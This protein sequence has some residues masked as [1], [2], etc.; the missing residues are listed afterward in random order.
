MLPWWELGIKQGCASASPTSCSTSKPAWAGASLPSRS[1]RQPCEGYILPYRTSPVAQANQCRGAR[2]PLAAFLVA[3]ESP[4]G[5][6]GGCRKVPPKSNMCS[7]LVLLVGFLLEQAPKRA[8]QHL[9]CL[10]SCGFPCTL[11]PQLC[12]ITLPTDFETWAQQLAD[13]NH[14]PFVYPRAACAMPELAL[15]FD[16][17]SHGKSFIKSSSALR[18]LASAKTK[19]GAIPLLLCRETK[20]KPN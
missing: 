15:C 7:F 20:R 2:N 10:V 4:P 3:F 8:S 14:R 16:H 12:C 18:T 17:Q 6:G 19:L 11:T 1:W 13:A 5:V 9:T